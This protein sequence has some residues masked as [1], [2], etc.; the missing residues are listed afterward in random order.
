MG[1]WNFGPNED[2]AKSV[3]WILEESSK[4]LIGLEY[5]YSNEIIF[6]EA[7]YLK[8][9][10]SK[11]K[12]Y[13]GWKP[14]WNAEEVIEKTINWYLLRDYKEQTSSSL[15]LKDIHDFWSISL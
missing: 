8:L 13:L 12:N 9:D 10:S 7:H 4:Y 11:A 1:G 14:V 6:N 2:S 5:E 15:M 3:R